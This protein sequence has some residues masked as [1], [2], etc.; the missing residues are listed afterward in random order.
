MVRIISLISG[1]GGV[2][3]TLISLNLSY[4]LSNFGFKTLLIDFNFTTPH[5]SLFL[6][7]K[8]KFTLNEFLSEEADFYEILNPT[9]NF[10]YISPSLNLEEIT[11]LKLENL[12]K[13]KENLN[14]FDFVLL[15][16]APGF[17]REAITAIKFSEEIIIVSNP[18]I[19][20]LF[21]S[22]KC[23][24]LANK[25]NKKVLG[26]I[27][28]RYEKDSPLNLKDFQNLINTN[29]LSIIEESKKA[30]YADLRR[31]M[32]Y[33]LDKNFRDQINSIISKIAGI[34]IKKENTLKKFLN[35]FQNIFSKRF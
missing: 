6:T 29:I 34:E 25:L 10:F 32:L 5:I 15:D 24:Q 14:F 1:K 8:P 12:E 27:I 16:S 23:F 21:D 18:T 30:K 26:I 35:I 9:F 31:E 3:K 7:S 20:S 4:A 28:N 13:L 11:S 22:I 19:S 2:G 17:G 33:N